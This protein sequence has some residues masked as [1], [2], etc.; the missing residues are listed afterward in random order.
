MPIEYTNNESLACKNEN[1][2]NGLGTVSL[3]LF[4]AQVGE[5]SLPVDFPA[6]PVDQSPIYEGLK[7][8]LDLTERTA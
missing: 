5:E 8:E 7:S 1:I 6:G 3:Q 2:L 4:Y